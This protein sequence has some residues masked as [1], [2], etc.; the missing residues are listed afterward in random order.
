MLEGG[1]RLFSHHTCPKD[2]QS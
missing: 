2:L 1:L